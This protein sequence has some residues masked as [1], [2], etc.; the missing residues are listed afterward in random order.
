MLII[1]GLIPVIWTALLIA[2]Y[3]DGGLPSLI[4]NF[5]RIMEEPFKIVWCDKSLKSIIIC[6]LCYSLGMGIYFSS[7]KNYR[8]GTEH[9][10]AVWG[11]V[12][13]LRKKYAQR[14][15]FSNILLTRNLSI[16]LDGRRHRR[17]LNVLVLGS[18]GAGKTRVYVKPNLMQANSSYIVLDPKGKSFLS[19]I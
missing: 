1:G 11:S 12:T 13:R 4:E 7:S 6:V 17:N 9:G 16:G 3:I 18:S 10:S 8:R 19:C 5:G 14:D 15:R 2:P